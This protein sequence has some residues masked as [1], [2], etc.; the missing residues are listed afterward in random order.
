MLSDKILC[1]KAFDSPAYYP[2]SNSL[3]EVSNLRT[4]LNPSV[5][6]GQLVWPQNNPLNQ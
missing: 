2:Y 4:W 1:Y 6:A 3:W 5:D